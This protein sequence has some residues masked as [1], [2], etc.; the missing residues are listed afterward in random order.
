VTGGRRNF[1]FQVE[2]GLAGLPFRVAL[3]FVIT[4]AGLAGVLLR[5][6]A[7]LVAAWRPLVS[8]ARASLPV[9]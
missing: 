8:A 7:R 4:F 3:A 1:F 9:R 2:P 5:L 6:S